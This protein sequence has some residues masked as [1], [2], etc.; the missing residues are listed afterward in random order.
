MG[1]ASNASKDRWNAKS[2]DSF[3]IRVPKGRKDAVD[4]YAREQGV[5]VNGLVNQF[6]RDLVGM[7][8]EEWK[9]KDE[10]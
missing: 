6:L 10:E 5:S 1:K 4:A 7:S 2:Y 8:E 9:R 3:H